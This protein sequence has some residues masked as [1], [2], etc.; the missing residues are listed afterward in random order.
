[1]NTNKLKRLQSKERSF[2]YRNNIDIC[3]EEAVSSI[4]FSSSS[5]SSLSS[6]SCS[7]LSSV[8]DYEEIDNMNEFDFEF[9]ERDVFDQDTHLSEEDDTFITNSDT[10]NTSI[11]LG[12]NVTLKEFSVVFLSL[13]K[14][15]K[16]SE[17]GVNMLLKFLFAILP[18]GNILPK[19]Y[20][21]ILNSFQIEKV[22][23]HFVCAFV[24]EHL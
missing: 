17:K 7:S 2:K 24:L 22:T 10:V 3:Y 11:Y 5:M 1:M 8:K 13:V 19:S 20:Q 18:E 21:T 9:F 12:S 6:S 23:P 15:L 16:L 14:R 4:N